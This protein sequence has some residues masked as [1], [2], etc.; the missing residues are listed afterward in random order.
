MNSKKTLLFFWFAV[1]SLGLAA[2]PLQTNLTFTNPTCNN[3]NG[4]LAV[5]PTGGTAP[6]SYEWILAPST[7]PISSASSLSGL[8]AGYYLVKVTDAN[9]SF[10]IDTI[11][12]NNGIKAFV[13]RNANAICPLSNGV[14]EVILQSGG[15]APFT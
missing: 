12:L 4:T 8:G 15:T 5:A 1:L 7:N 6:Y 10:K 14:A 9:N 13:S 11:V 2:Q 3:S